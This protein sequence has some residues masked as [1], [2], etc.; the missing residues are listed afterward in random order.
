[1][2]HAVAQAISEGYRREVHQVVPRQGV[3]PREGPNQEAHETVVDEGLQRD[4][5]L[6]WAI[7]EGHLRNF[8]KDRRLHRLR[9]RRD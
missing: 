5:C 1:M 8:C 3:H 2:D 4:H 9:F 6:H 7:S